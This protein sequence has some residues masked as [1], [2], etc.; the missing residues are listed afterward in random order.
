MSLS[1]LN[2]HSN[3]HSP[4][5]TPEN[6][7]NGI[8]NDLLRHDEFDTKYDVPEQQSSLDEYKKLYNALRDLMIYGVPISV[9]EFV[10]IG[11]QS[12]GKTSVVSQ[13]AK[14]AV[15]VMQDGTASRSPTRFKL[16]N[17]PKKK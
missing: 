14:I 17:N 5:S 6:M 2:S 7:M 16:V 8:P 15:G 12:A 4:P 1:P 3:L 10:F 11:F 9:P 13:L